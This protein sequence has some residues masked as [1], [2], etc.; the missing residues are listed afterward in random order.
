ML[1]GV[2]AGIICSLYSC[3]LAPLTVYMPSL[4]AML[5]SCLMWTSPS[6]IVTLECIT[7][8]RPAKPVMEAKSRASTKGT[9]SWSRMQSR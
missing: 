6:K 1:S 5:A 9:P 4:V 2:Y 7:G 3:Y 8:T